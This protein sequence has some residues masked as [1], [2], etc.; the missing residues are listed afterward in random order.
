MIGENNMKVY[1][2]YQLSTLD[3]A[4]INDIEDEIFSSLGINGTCEIL[5]VFQSLDKAKVALNNEIKLQCY[6]DGEWT[7][8]F[9]DTNKFTVAFTIIKRCNIVLLLM[10]KNYNKL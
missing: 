8:K 10:K 5:N 7:Y 9:L 2:M 3:C 6:D 4:N 1:V